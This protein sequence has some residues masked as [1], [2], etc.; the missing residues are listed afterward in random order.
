MAT[1][2]IDGRTIEFLDGESIM[3]ACHRA[4]VY[5]PAICSHPDLPPFSAGEPSET[6]YRSDEAYKDDPEK[7]AGPG[8][9]LCFVEI[10]G[11]EAPV[12]ACETTAV[13]EM[14]VVTQSQALETLRR[15]NLSALLTGHPRL[16]I[17]CPQR[18]GCDRLKCT[19]SVPPE[20]RCCSKFNDCELKAVA[21]YVGINRDIPE[22]VPAGIPSIT[23]GKLFEFNFN[24]CIGCLRCV[25][26]CHMQEVGALGF[27][28]QNGKVIVG[29]VQ[30]TLQKSG[31]KFCGAC[32]AVCPTGAMISTS[33]KCG[34]KLT[35][36][37]VRLPPKEYLE[38]NERVVA[39][40]PEEGGVIQLLDEG[41][42]IVYIAGTSNMRRELNACLKT[43]KGV[44]FLVLEEVSKFSQRQNELIQ[45]YMDK[46]GKQPR[47]N[48]ELDDLF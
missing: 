28:C 27:V 1:L 47:I 34:N 20:Q 7:E 41:E 46:H 13:E 25:R 11:E 14:Q 48:A 42:N 43:A 29:T 15:K 2:T 38:F 24:L 12:L 5:I 30:P 9:G 45:Q 18:E 33:E 3:H 4:D 32:V 19:L 37:P 23:G 10:E 26:A 8:C 31:C 6:V 40:V 36:T 22:Y 39:E 44:K 16:C 21:D 35:I 17:I